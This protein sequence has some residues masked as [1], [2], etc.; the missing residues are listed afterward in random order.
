MRSILCLS[1]LFYFNVN[2]G[3]SPDFQIFTVFFGLI[4]S[5]AFAQ[6]MKEL[7]NKE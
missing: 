2:Y 3:E 5:L 1:I 6:D 4:S 7:W